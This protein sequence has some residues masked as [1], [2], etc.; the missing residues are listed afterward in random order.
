MNLEKSRG[1]KS[2]NQNN[3]SPAGR[4]ALGFVLTG[5]EASLGGKPLVLPASLI[6]NL[7]SESGR[8]DVNVVA[9]EGAL[10]FELD[11]AVN[12]GVERVVL[13]RAD[14]VAG[15]ELRAALTNDDAASVDGCI[16]ENLPWSHDRCGWSR[17]LSCVPF[18]ML[19]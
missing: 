10:H 8:F 4:S 15:V 2:N 3:K 18:S 12:E 16:A 5:P 19:C 1:K 13:A 6:S 14:V 11:G 9:A 7:G 17:R